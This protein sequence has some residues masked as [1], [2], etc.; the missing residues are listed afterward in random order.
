MASATWVPQVES[1]S[2]ASAAWDAIGMELTIFAVTALCAVA[3]RTLTGKQWAPLKGDGKAPAKMALAAKAPPAT[4]GG[5]T[6]PARVAPPAG[7][8]QPGLR[9]AD[10]P[11]LI[12]DEV[13]GGVREQHGMKFAARV[14]ALYADFRACLSAPGAPT[15]EQAARRSRHTAAE[16][17]MTVVQCAVRTSR[18]HLVDGIIQDMVRFKVER[19]L[20]FYEVTMKQL[21]AQKQYRLALATYDRLREDGLEPSVVTCSCLIGFAA[22]VG[23]LGRAV[24]FFG[25]LS[26]MTT[27]S[28]RAYMTVL[29]VHAKRQDWAASLALFRE[30]RARGV[31]RDSLVL[32]FVLATGVSAGRVEEAAALVEEAHREAPGMLDVVSYNTVIK[33]YTQRGDAAGALEALAQMGSRGVAPNSIT[34]NTAMDAAVRGG[35]VAEAW[36]LLGSMRRAGLAPDKFT[37]SILG[38]ASPRA[39]A[40]STSQRSSACLRRWGAAATLASSP[41]STPPCWR[42]RLLTRRCWPRCSRRCASRASPR[43]PRR[44]S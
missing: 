40:G 36:E 16:F 42:R 23:E 9:D 43:R 2:M 4:P 39:G 8:P 41:R 7:G 37:C 32:N 20:R 33:G 1:A 18:S 29:R 10:T 19:S 21:A 35:R 5:A 44:S 11:A 25:V 34:F 12:I 24:E 14:L 28:I 22:E 15:V 13:V 26:S 27:P 38:G 17:Y 3:V 30:M 6:A 31:K